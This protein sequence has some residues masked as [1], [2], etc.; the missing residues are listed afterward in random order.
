MPVLNSMLFIW[1]I[2]LLLTLLAAR[3]ASLRPSP[4][5][6]HTRTSPDQTSRPR[7]VAFSS[8]SS[9]TENSIRSEEQEVERQREVAQALLKLGTDLPRESDL[10]VVL[11]KALKLVHDFL[12]AD[13]GFLFLDQPDQQSYIL[14]ATVGN[15]RELPA[16]GRATGYPRG[17]GMLGWIIQYGRPLVVDDLSQDERWKQSPELNTVRRSAIGAPL[18]INQEMLGVLLFTSPHPV[19]FDADQLPVITAAASQLANALYNS[20]LFKLIRDQAARQGG[21]IREKR[22]EASK[23]NAILESIAEGVLVTD[24]HNQVAL[25]NAAAERILDLDR[26][27]VVGRPMADLI[28]IFGEVGDR[29]R[30][31]VESW[32]QNGH[33]DSEAEAPLE[34]RLSLEDDRIVA[35]TLAPVI[36]EERFLGT[37]STFRDITREVEVD[38]LKSEFVAT[39]SHELRTPMT[40]VKG[41]VEMLLMEAVGELNDQ[42]RKFLRV[43]KNNVDRL[44]SLVNDL[45]DISRIEAGRVQLD[46]EP[47]DLKALLEETAEV[48]KRRTRLESKPLTIGLELPE[49]LPF[50]L[51]DR[52]RLRQIVANLMENSFNYTPVDGNIQLSAH[53]VDDQIEVAVADN[54]IG[55]PSSDRERVFERFFRGDQ[56]LDM[57]VAGTGL[58]LSIVRQLVDMHGGTIELESDGVPGQGTT[59]RFTLPLETSENINKEQA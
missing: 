45:L 4:V 28:G 33:G 37:V 25:L 43:I 6:L 48:F 21:M 17:K 40:S 49:S 9:V 13:R 59:F 16:G 36:F 39:V 18:I 46:L 11:N 5:Y 42:Q 27:Q 35:F 47:L 14:R 57:A 12:E 1:L 56:A 10:D 19:A 32:A 44:G 53:V 31:V 38:R 58:G 8:G 52:D 2:L 30:R 41:Y 34:S 51:A 24:E 20:E 7:P 50:V 54:G 55:I 3:L 23:S 22:I 26:S 29:W 15:E